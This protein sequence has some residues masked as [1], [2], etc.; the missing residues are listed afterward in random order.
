MDRRAQPR[1][2][3]NL[4]HFTNHADIQRA[5]VL[6]EDRLHPATASLPATWVASDEWY[7]FPSSPRGEPGVRI[8]ATIDEQTYDGGT[9]GADHPLAWSH[10]NLGGRAFYT[11]LGHVSSRWNESNFVAHIT[12]AVR[13]ALHLAD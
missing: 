7:N 10:D 8:L 1:Q 6:V 3:H 11:A 9:Q 4:R 5:T 13:W 2:R 12:G